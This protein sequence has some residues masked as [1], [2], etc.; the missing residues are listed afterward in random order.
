MASMRAVGTRIRRREVVRR[1]TLDTGS[2]SHW[3]LEGEVG[4]GHKELI[5]FEIE[6][7]N[8]YYRIK[9]IIKTILLIAI[10]PVYQVYLSS[11]C[12]W[13]VMDCYSI[14]LSEKKA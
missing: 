2:G 4:I 7:T 5:C 10:Y 9:N 1:H 8:I 12:D 14:L 13:I 6:K 11:F 3:I